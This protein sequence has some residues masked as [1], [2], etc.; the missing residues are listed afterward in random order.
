MN[1]AEAIKPVIV[2]FNYDLRLDDNPAFYHAVH[3][4]RP[5]IC[6]Y[7]L[8]PKNHYSY[9]ASEYRLNCALRDLDNH[10]KAFGG[11]L[12]LAKGDWCTV[13]KSLV[14]KSLATDIFVNKNYHCDQREDYQQVLATLTDLSVTIHEY[15]NFLLLD[16]AIILDLK[17]AGYKV[18][19]PFYKT[20]LACYQPSSYAFLKKLHQRPFN[21]WGDALGLKNVDDSALNMELPEGIE[22]ELTFTVS[23]AQAQLKDFILNRLT[24]YPVKRDFFADNPTSLLACY[25]NSG[26]LSVHRVWHEVC[27]ADAPLASKTA[28]LRQLIW[29]DFV[30]HIW[31]QNLDLTQVS[32]RPIFSDSIWSKNAKLFAAW[33][34]GKTGIPVVD[35]GMQQLLQTGLMHNRVRMI[36]ASFLTK[37][38]MHKWQDGAAWFM[39][40]L[41]DGDVALNAFNWQWVAGCGADAAPYFR[42][43][44]PV[45]QG[46]KFDAQGDYIK[47][48]I[49]ELQHLPAKWIHAPH[50]APRDILHNA[51]VVL[52][53]N[54]P[55]PVID[56]AESAKHALSLY[57]LNGINKNGSKN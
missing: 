37:N 36:V 5:L 45:L 46:K 23:H 19:T 6:I 52:G 21:F 2:W 34:Y 47:R 28:F 57:K 32:M 8:S 33:C 48:F 15:A 55:L 40:H 3:T 49:P 11:R 22:P 27:L 39:Q 51:G 31:Q 43:F 29:R 44:N 17:P 1:V 9:A 10:L 53:Q 50:L 7:V 4:G 25:L 16:P 38:L 41:L 20:A 14:H 56:L 42:I 30:Y 13:L 26:Q 54:Y 18:F 12:L 35:A 24:A